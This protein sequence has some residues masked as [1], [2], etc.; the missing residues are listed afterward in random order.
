MSHA[1][2]SRVDTLTIFHSHYS[3]LVIYL[4]SYLATCLSYFYCDRGF[5]NGYSNSLTISPQQLP[6]ECI[7]IKMLLKLITYS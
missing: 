1:I 2:S 6:E 7:E 3:Q 5:V 4:M